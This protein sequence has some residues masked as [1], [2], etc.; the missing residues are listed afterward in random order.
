MP[1][2]D[3]KLPGGG[4]AIVCT[5]GRKPKP[6]GLCPQP[7]RFL[8][9]WK[10]ESGTCDKPLCAEHATQ[11]ASDKHLCPEH[12]REFTAWLAAKKVTT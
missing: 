3:L 5:R 10:V 1:C 8:C 9:D 11:V 6:C 7:H 2:D 4:V 12:Q